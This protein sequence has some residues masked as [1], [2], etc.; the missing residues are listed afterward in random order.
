MLIL[1]DSDTL[2]FQYLDDLK[3][4]VDL[5]QKVSVVDWLLAHAVRVEYAEN[6]LLFSFS[7]VKILL[8]FLISPYFYSSSLFASLTKGLE[9]LV[10]VSSAGALDA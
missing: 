10:A 4:P 2:V 1:L 3:C 6:G 9:W 7:P 5:S 8:H